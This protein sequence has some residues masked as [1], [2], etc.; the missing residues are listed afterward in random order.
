MILAAYRDSNRT[1]PLSCSWIWRS[2]AIATRLNSLKRGNESN[3]GG[4]GSSADPPIGH[5]SNQNLA[6][7]L[8]LDLAPWAIADPSHRRLTQEILGAYDS[9]RSLA[10]HRLEERGRIVERTTDD[11]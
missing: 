10:E 9:N 1:L 2:T 8:Q 7:V 5:H 4:I 3:G 11:Q 6:F